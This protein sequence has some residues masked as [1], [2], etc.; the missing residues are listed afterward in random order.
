E[1]TSDLWVVSGA[2]LWGAPR[3]IGLSG[4]VIEVDREVAAGVGTG[5]LSEAAT[6]TSLWDLGGDFEISATAGGV[7]APASLVGEYAGRGGPETAPKKEAFKLGEKTENSVSNP[8]GHWGLNVSGDFAGAFTNDAVT[9]WL[10]DQ[11]TLTGV[12]GDTLGVSAA[13]TTRTHAVAGAAAIVN[14]GRGQGATAGSSGSVGMIEHD[15]LVEAQVASVT[16]AGLAVEVQ[17]V[18]NKLL[19]SFAGGLQVAVVTDADLQLAGSVAFNQVTNTTGAELTGVTGTGLEEVQVEAVSSDEAWA[20]AGVLSVNID[21]A[22]L[23]GDLKDKA[24]TIVGVG[25]SGAMQGLTNATT[26]QVS[27]SELE[28]GGAVAVEAADYTRSLVLS[29]GVDVTVSAGTDVTVGGMFAT[30]NLRPNTQ[31]LVTGS[32]ITSETQPGSQPLDVSALLIPALVGT[33]GYV[34]LDWGK[35]FSLKENEVGVGVGAGVVVTN[36]AGDGTDLAET[37]AR[38]TASDLDWNTGEVAVTAYSGAMTAGYE[39]SATPTTTGTNSLYLLAVAGSAQAENG[40][41]VSVGVD[42]AGDHR[43]D[44]RAR[45][46]G[47]G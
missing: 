20:A 47:G 22:D 7:F 3:A 4:S 43:L 18:N 13:N 16:L 45:H 34:S 25:A 6:M 9:A 39:T 11:G 28:V 26:A 37:V 30:T 36:I 19:G 38:V 12:S 5:A 41:A 23:A 35:L 1:D 27:D 46:L 29:A 42:V 40:S 24:K 31:A 44:A 10:A 14:A 32:Q 33:A 21:R 2:V 15:S 8:E 17:A